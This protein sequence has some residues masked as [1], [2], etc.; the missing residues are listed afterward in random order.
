MMRATSRVLRRRFASAPAAKKQYE[1]KPLGPASAALVEK[2]SRVGAENYA[3]LP[4]V[5]A[6]GEG[7]STARKSRRRGAGQFF[8]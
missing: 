5:L 6:R 8:E 7:A 2:E 1:P 4:V 3:P